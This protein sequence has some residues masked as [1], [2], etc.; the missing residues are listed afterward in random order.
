MTSYASKLTSSPR[1][2]SDKNRRRKMGLNG[3]CI[4]VFSVAADCFLNW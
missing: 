2:S 3:L 1:N 4:L